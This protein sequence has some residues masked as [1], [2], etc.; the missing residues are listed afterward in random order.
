MTPGKKARRVATDAIHATLTQQGSLDSV[1]NGPDGQ[2]LSS[3]ELALAR[4]IASTTVRHWFHLQQILNQLL[5]R[6]FRAKDQILESLL[7]GALAQL[8]FTRQ[9]DHAVVAESVA[10]APELGKPWARGVC[11]A[12]LRNF[13]RDKS[14]FLMQK[15]TDEAQLNHPSWLIGKLKKAYPEHYQSILNANNQRAPMVLRNNV[16][17]QT[18]QQYLDRLHQEGI[19]AELG[20]CDSIVL[21]APIDVSRLPGFEQGHVSVQDSSAQYAAHFLDA[22]HTDRVLDA[23]AAPG[24]KTCHLLEHTPGLELTALD[25]QASRMTRIQQNLDRLGLTAQ[26]ICADASIPGEWCQEHFDKILLDAPCSGTG[27]IRRHPDIRIA[28]DPEQIKETVKIQR[29]IL[30]HCW[31]ILAPGGRLLYATCSVLPEENTKQ[32]AAFLASHPEATLE[33]LTAEH[34]VEV[35]VGLQILPGEGNVDGFYYASLVKSA[36]QTGESV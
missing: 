22:Q 4:M 16:N 12:V 36:P 14:S 28:R 31:S 1:L 8:A 7:M 26:L 30:E 18:A 6:P 2:A 11:N 25:N 15:H 9:A 35:P 13:L 24:G 27:V 20:S 10:M 3:G 34:Q 29:S 32:I 21:A 17:H 19:E 33:P 23:C 5:E